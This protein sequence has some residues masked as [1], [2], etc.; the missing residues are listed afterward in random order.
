MS[1]ASDSGYLP[2]SIPELMEY[3]RQGINAQFGTSYETETFAGT[4]WYKYFYA[5]VQRLSENEIKTSEI[6]LRLQQYFQTTNEKITRPNTTHPGIIDYI[7]A[8]GYRT[9]TKAPIDADA[10]KV[11]ICVDVNNALPNYADL[12]KEICG[13]VKDCVVAGVISQGT[14]VETIALPNAQSFDFKFYLPTKIPVKLRLTINLSS[15]NQFTVLS[16]TEIAEKLYANILARYRL[17]LDFE[18]ERYFSVVDAPWAGSILLE[19]S[20]D[21]GATWHDEIF[22]ADFDELFTLIVTDITVVTV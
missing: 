3:V 1:Y 12:K 18:P 22:E 6:F 7:E 21:A 8:R 14:Q 5:L 4:N 16:D 19:W 10:G 2:S 17:G 20:D 11:F 9:S 13:Y 15:N